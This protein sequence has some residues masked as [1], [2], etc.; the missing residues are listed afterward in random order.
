MP[1]W[2]R[3]DENRELDEELRFHLEQEARLRMDRGEAADSAR[4]NARRDFGNVT[5]TA[6][7]TR[8]MW[9]WTAWDR[10]AQDLRFALRMMRKNLAFT[11]LA[12]AAL[13][14]GIG[15]T[16]AIFSVVNSVLLRPLPFPDPARLVMIWEN[17]PHSS[18]NNR[19]QSGNFLAWRERN[20]S[21]QDIA[22]M[23]QMGVNVEGESDA[24]QVPGLLVTAGFFPILEVPPLLGRAIRP[25]DT[26]V[27]SAGVVV[28]SYGFW[29]RRFGGQARA[30]GQKI[31][32]AGITAEIIGVMPPRFAF[33]TMPHIALYL[34]MRLDPVQ[35]IRD[36]RNDITVAR[37]RPGVTFQAAYSEMRSIAGQLAIERPDRDA[38]WNATAVPLLEQTVGEARTTLLVLLGAVFFVL[39]IACSNVAN[40]LLMRNSARRREMTVRV[41]LG[42]GRW[43]LMHQLAIESLLLAVAGGGLGLLLALAGVPALI[44]MLPPEFPLPRMSEISIDPAVLS[45]CLAVTLFC[46]LFFGIFPAMQVNRGRLSEGLRQGGRGGSLANRG[47]RNTL[48]VAEI[49]LALLLVVGAG[50]MLRSFLLLHSVDPGFRTDRLLTFRMVL[51]APGRSGQQVFAL[52]AERV[53][54]MLDRVRALPDVAAAS[55]IH[56]LPLTGGNSGTDYRRMDRPQPPPGAGFGGGVSVVS[57]DYFH[58]MGIPLLSG[59]EFDAQD[60]AASPRVMMLNQAAADF[61]YPNE[62]PL[63]KRMVVSWGPPPSDM[64]IIGVAANIRHDGLDSQPDPCIFLPHQ[65]QPNGFAFL[66]VRTRGAAANIISEVKEQIRAVSPTQGIQEIQTMEN[67]MGDSIARPKLEVAV[68]SVFGVIALVLA[69]VGIYA[70]ISYSVE[71]RTREMGIRLALGAS[72]GSV[73]GMVM[74][75]G[76]LLAAAGIASGLVAALAL[77]RYLETLLYAIRPTDPL[78]FAAVSAIL[79]TAALAGCLFPA[80][81]ATRVDPA[82]VLREE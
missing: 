76:L 30:L 48:V 62:N 14:L 16:T 41:A 13:A 21:F 60:R 37:L 70:V 53:R 63:G 67:V 32:V 31:V 38:E 72:P 40:L 8:Q 19:V 36:G 51:M 26:A 29:Q 46:G 65:Q 33:P 17:P 42:A 44:R 74:R 3:R 71:Q 55:T 43:R 34:P 20:R 4:R 47:L 64:E 57:D 59:R 49:A 66:L 69:C 24:V 78:V 54:Q 77:T 52:R 15:A 81:R 56:I 80:R 7:V 1:F 82:L 6:E 10:A 58:T 61:F 11:G 73:L 35:A 75:E 23:F 9:G 5:R 28:L 45:F 12:L 27:G 25:E 68:F 79:A 50:L 2:N 18:H 22:A 39:L